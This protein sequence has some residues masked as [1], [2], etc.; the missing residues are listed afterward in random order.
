MY[1]LLSDQVDYPYFYFL[2]VNKS[3]PWMKFAYHGHIFWAKSSVLPQNIRHF[4]STASSIDILW[5]KLCEVTPGEVT[6]EIMSNKIMVGIIKF[7]HVPLSLET[8][9]KRINM[10]FCL[11]KICHV[12]VSEPG[13]TSLKFKLFV[14]SHGGTKNTNHHR[15]LYVPDSQFRWSRQ[16]TLDLYRAWKPSVWRN[17]D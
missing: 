14:S 16:L 4:L 10:V 11:V 13:Q 5:T 6:I 12:M 1:Q 2:V 9:Y 15:Y 8:E 7:V 17:G 3:S